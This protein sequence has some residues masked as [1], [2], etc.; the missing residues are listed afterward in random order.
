MMRHFHACQDCGTKTPCSGELADNYDGE[1]AIIC[2]DFHQLNGTVDSDFI[3]ERCQ[4]LREDREAAEAVE[5][6]S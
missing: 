2:L 1:P 3:C 4:Y 6:D 5:Q